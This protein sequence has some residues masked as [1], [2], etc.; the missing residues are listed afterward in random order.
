MFLERLYRAANAEDPDG[1]VTYV[2]YPSTE[3]LQLPFVDFVCFN[4]YLHNEQPFKNY[5]ARLQMTTE[6]KPLL[7]GEFGID[8]L[9]EGEAQTAPAR[10]S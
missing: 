10:Q 3:Y 7:L 4:L 1:L 9:R 5:L 2:Y 8:S 6:S